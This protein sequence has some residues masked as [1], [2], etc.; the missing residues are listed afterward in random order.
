MVGALVVREFLHGELRAELEKLSRQRFRAPDA[1]ST[2][3]YSVPTLE[4]WYYA[5]KKHGP[6]ALVPKRRSDKGH[7]RCLDP[8]TREL[9]CDIREQT[10]SASAPLILK[11]L[12]DEGRLATSAVSEQ[13]VRKL[14]ADRGRG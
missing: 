7:G 8:E 1:D 5:C 4:R 12:Q 10:R 3:C 13:T 14:F 11:T 6:G 9:R 2:R